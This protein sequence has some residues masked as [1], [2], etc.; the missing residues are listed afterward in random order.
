MLST[1]GCT[2]LFRAVCRWRKHTASPRRLRPEAAV[3]RLLYA[4]VA[5]LGIGIVGALTILRLILHRRY[6]RR[7]EA[8]FG[9]PTRT[10]IA[11]ASGLVLGLALYSLSGGPTSDPSAHECI[12]ASAG[13][14]CCGS[15]RL[16]GGRRHRI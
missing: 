1:R 9:S 3:D 2:W 10:G 14:F 15:H 7:E 16:L 8:G 4:V 12:C 11:V 13:G 6:L 5:N